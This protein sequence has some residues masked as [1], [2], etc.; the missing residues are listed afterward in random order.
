MV[1]AI[2]AGCTVIGRMVVVGEQDFTRI[3]FEH[4]SDRRFRSS[5]REGRVAY[6]ADDKQNDRQCNSKFLFFF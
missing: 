6:P 4:R 5:Y 3:G 1:M 2:G